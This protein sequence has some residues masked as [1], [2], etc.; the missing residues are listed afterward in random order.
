A[1]LDATAKYPWARCEAGAGTA[2]PITKFGVYGED[3]E[4]FAWM[5]A[6]R[7][8][9]QRCLEAQV[10]DWAD[11]VA[12]S[13]HD[14]EDAVVA[15][16]LDVGRMDAGERQEVCR[17]AAALYSPRDAAELDAVLGDLLR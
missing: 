6:G 4:A 5:R 17:I 16:L 8:D 2:D 14:I 12:Y 7:P 13:V 15:G 1:S 9:G 10:M 11:D 3:A